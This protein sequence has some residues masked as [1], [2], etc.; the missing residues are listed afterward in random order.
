M[1][2]A[3]VVVAVFLTTVLLLTACSSDRKAVDDVISQIDSIT[4]VSLSSGD[5]IEKAEKAYEALSKKQ[6]EKVTNYEALKNA[7]IRYDT[8]WVFKDAVDEYNDE[9]QTYN[10]RLLEYDSK[11]WEVDDVNLEF[12]QYIQQIKKQGI[13]EA[14]ANDPKTITDLQKAVDEA[15]AAIAENTPEYISMQLPADQMNL[16]G[17]SVS[18]ITEYTEK[19]KDAKLD[20]DAKCKALEESINSVVIPDY[21]KEK[22]DL[23][24][25]WKAAEYSVASLQQVTDPKEDFVLSRIREIDTVVFTAPATSEQDPFGRL[26][27]ADGY[28]VCVF[29]Q[30]SRVEE[31]APVSSESELL[32][33]GKEAGGCVEVYRIKEQAEKRDAD[34]NE[35]AGQEEHMMLGTCIIR[36]STYL[37]AEQQKDLED[38]IKGVFL[39]VDP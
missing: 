38:T 24:E 5:R 33:I 3:G 11:I 31:Y 39:R 25:K 17:M 21:T 12:S 29:F 23:E 16:E 14:E 13:L 4:K 35:A 18:Q 34:L 10:D 30:D 7:R 15:E 2:G 1:K 36:P 20:L 27:K 37:T 8:M 19:L 28:L 9:V 6:K 22:A 32:S 26:K